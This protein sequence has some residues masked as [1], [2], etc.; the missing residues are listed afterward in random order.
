MSLA[1]YFTHKPDMCGSAPSRLEFIA[2]MAFGDR[3][4][5]MAQ[6]HPIFDRVIRPKAN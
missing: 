2:I 3:L 1:L 6:V 5:C 4:H